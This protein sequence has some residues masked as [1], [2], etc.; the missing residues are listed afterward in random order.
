[1]VLH[2][3]TTIAVRYQAMVHCGPIRQTASILNMEADCLRTG[4]KANVHFKFVKHP[5]FLKVGQRLVFREGRTK[6]VGNV[7]KVTAHI[8]LSDKAGGGH[9][10][11][12]MMARNRETRKRDEETVA[13]VTS[14]TS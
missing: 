6:A 14:A 10:P 5:E 3:P 4:D 11:Q 2:H 1:M 13:E 7:T 12:K 8:P 9:K